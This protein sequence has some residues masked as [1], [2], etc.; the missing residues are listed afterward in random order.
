MIC[1]FQPKNETNYFVLVTG[2]CEL[3]ARLPAALTLFTRYST[4]LNKNPQFYT[5]VI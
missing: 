4:K 2:N 5:F 1:I 3:A